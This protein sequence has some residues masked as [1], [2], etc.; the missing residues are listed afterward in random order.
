MKKYFII[1][2]IFLLLSA[3]FAQM[4]GKRP[5]QYGFDVNAKPP[6]YYDVY[7]TFDDNDLSPQLNVLFNIQN[8]LLFFTKSDDG[9]EGGYDIVI[10]VKDLSTN[11]TVF[12]HLWKEKIYEREFKSTNSKERYQ[13]NGKTFNTVLSPGEY[14]VHLELTDKAT[15][16]S[17]K[18]ERI[19][20]IPDLESSIYFNEIKFLSQDD[21]LSAE[22]VVGDGQSTV[23]FNNNLL[24]Y[25]EIIHSQSSPLSLTSV[26]YRINENEKTEIRRKEHSLS[27]EN[28]NIS[29]YEVLER[30]ILVEGDYLLEYDVISAEDESK[31]QK[32]FSVLWYKKPLYLYD[33]ELAIPPLK[34]LLSPEEWDSIED[35]SEEKLLKWLE[36]YWHAKDPDP[37]TPLNEIMFEFYNRV[38]QA[39]KKY[40]DPYNEG[41]TTDR[42][43][44]L[45][46]YGK[47][48]EVESYRYKIKSKPYEIWYYRSENKKLVFIDVDEDDTYPL[49]SVEDIGEQTN[50]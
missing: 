2:W 1:L 47:P 14:E 27:S 39:N 18:S 31:V 45:I 40:A 26:L 46:L 5:T 23:E 15:G 12:S 32:K 28:K 29:F 11:S 6:V 34:Y 24:S 36:E 20:T 17:F 8:D 16:N 4:T 9:Y 42:G 33:L 37:D 44:S 41:W 48:D 13:V 19:L 25:F 30:K 38:L 21:S 49:M 22:I 35:L 43:K 7:I 10:A 3:A 50:E